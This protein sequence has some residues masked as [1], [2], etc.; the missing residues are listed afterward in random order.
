MAF[1]MK[2]ISGDLLQHVNHFFSEGFNNNELIEFSGGI[3]HPVVEGIFNEWYFDGIRMAY[4]D[5]NYKQP[6]ELKWD[7]D[8]NVD[9]ITFQANINGHV[10]M[11]ADDSK[12]IPLFG[13]YQHNLFYSAANTADTGYLKGDRNKSSIFFIQFTKNSFLRLTENANNALRIFNEHVQN[14]QPALLSLNNLSLDAFMLNVIRSI[15]NCPYKKQLKKMYLLSRAIEF[16]VLQ[17][18]AC[19]TVQQPA[20]KYIKTAYD[21]ECIMYA[22]EYVQNHLA[23][24]PGLSALAKIIGMNEYKLKRGFKEIT[25]NTVFGY[26]AHARLEIARRDLLEQNKTASQIACDL[27]YSSLQHFSYAFKAKFGKSPKHFTGN[28]DSAAE[29]V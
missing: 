29:D 10:Y 9:I 11:Q 22:K 28:H 21:I 12:H 15:I 23:N 2:H 25:G 20:Y 13:N 14:N 26:L 3:N 19:N 6:V 17:A 18:E 27:G 1:S 8:F 5:L 7:Y 4:A 24:P 16:L